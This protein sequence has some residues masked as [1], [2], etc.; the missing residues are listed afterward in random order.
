MN[1]V[2]ASVVASL[3]LIIV[4]FFLGRLFFVSSVQKEFDQTQLTLSQ[5]LNE[6]EAL[7]KDRKRLESTDGED[8]A[9]ARSSV[10]L[11]PGKEPGLV[12]QLIA[13]SGKVR[14]SSFE[15]LEPYFVK[16]ENEQEYSM[17]VDTSF[18]PNDDKLE[19]DEFG[20]P[21]GLPVYKD[22]SEW[23][24]VEIVPVRFKF[25]A[26]VVALGKFLKKI[27]TEL[28][29]NIIRS[30]DVILQGN[31]VARGTIVLLFPLEET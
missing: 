23:E 30:M 25:M 19:L 15:I 27:D 6:L 21:V 29:M 9:L 22:I 5:R 28:P 3:I 8:A 10:L 7:R 26:R 4:V 2:K 31:D 12:R 17:A 11:K 24:G 16:N 18:N 1:K 14:L 13:A 20:M